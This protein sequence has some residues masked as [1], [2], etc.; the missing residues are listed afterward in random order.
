MLDLCKILGVEEGEEFKIY[1]YEGIYFIQNGYLYIIDIDSTKK[2]SFLNINDI[3]GKNI[4]KLPKKKQFS[5][6]ELSILRNIDYR[7]KWV[8]RDRDGEVWIYSDKPK[9][10]D[11]LCNWNTY[12]S[13]NKSLEIIKNSLFTEIKWEDDEPVFIDDYVDR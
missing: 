10:E 7:Y 3:V 1:G 5:Q 12:C 9:K 4:I 11:N 2:K 8:A 13:F 6:D